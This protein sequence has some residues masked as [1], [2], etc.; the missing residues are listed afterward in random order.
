MNSEVELFTDTDA[1][2]S[3]FCAGCVA[4]P[5]NCPL[6]QNY[7]AQQLEDTIYAFI[8]DIKYNP[9]PLGGVLVDYEIVK[10]YIAYQLYFPQGWADLALVIYAVML[11]DE[12]IGEVLGTGGTGETASNDAAEA[13]FGIKCGDVLYHS[14][15]LDEKREQFAARGAISRIAG[16][17]ADGLVARCSQWRMPAKERYDGDFDVHTRNPMLIIGNTYDPVTPLASARNLSQTIETSVLLQQDT[18]G[19]SERCTSRPF[20]Q[21]AN[22][23]E[24][25]A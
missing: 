3:G 21:I 25:T 2:F 4:R 8:D 23:I 22:E 7:T 15:S 11:R 10:G 18:Y 14:Q 20:E 24:N 9:F 17:G 13:R 5:D 16:D 12:S 6:A 19:V 1:A